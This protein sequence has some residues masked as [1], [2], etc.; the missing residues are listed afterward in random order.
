MATHIGG[1]D[2]KSS[3]SYEHCQTAAIV[4]TLCVQW[5]F[6]IVIQ[7]IGFGFG[8]LYATD[9]LEE[10]MTEAFLPNVREAIDDCHLRYYRLG[11]GAEVAPAAGRKSYLREFAHMAAVGWTGSDGKIR[12]DCGGSLIWENY[13][14]TAAHCVEDDANIPPDVVRLGDINL[15]DDTDDQYAQQLK[16]VEIVRHPEH[17]FGSRYHDLALLRLEKN[18]TLHDTVAPGCLWNDE[19]EIPFPTMEAT[20]WGATGFGEKSTPILLK[21]SLGVVK[22]EECNKHYKVGDR[23]L[24]QGLMNYHLCA[25]D[26]KMDTCPGDSGGPLQMKLLHNG[27]MTPFVVAVTSF[28]GVCGQSIPGVYMKV[29]PYI[30]WIS[31]ELAKRGEIIRDYSFK[32]DACALRYV[33]LR[34][35]EDDVVKHTTDGREILNFNNFHM[36][37]RDSTQTVSVHWPADS[38]PVPSNCNGVVIDEDTIVTLARCAIT[39]RNQPSHIMLRN[40]RNDIVRVYRH[41]DYRPNSFYNDIAILKVKDRFT[42]S[43]DF[44]PACIWSAY[45]LPNP[46]FYVTG[47]GRYDLNTLTGDPNETNRTI[48]QL[49]PRADILDIGNCTLPE[50]YSSR[51]G[52]GVTTEHLCFGNKL[53]L[54]PDSCEM[55]YGAPLRRNIWRFERHFEHIYALNLLGK[56]CGFGRAA[57]GIRLSYHSEWLKSVLLPN[58]RYESH[59]VQFLNT[60]LNDLD[61]CTGTDGST[62]L[63]VNIN[64]CPKIRYDVQAKRN[65]QFCNGGT[66]VCCPYDNIRNETSTSMSAS[67]LDDCESRYKQ[68]HEMYESYQPDRIDHF[69]HTVY[70]GWKTKDGSTEWI[71]SGTLITRS[72]VVSSAYCLMA[73]GNFP[74]LVNVAEGNPNATW[75]RPK[76]VGIKEVI[77][78][79]GYNATTLQYDIGLVRLV[80]PIVPTARKYPICLWQNETHTPLVLYRMAADETMSNF[81]LNFPKYNSDC[82]QHLR[83]LGR[84]ELQSNELCTDIDDTP[85]RSISGGPLVWYHRNLNDNSSTQYLV[86]T[87]SSTISAQRLGIHVR[88][89][90]YIGWIKSIAFG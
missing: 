44:V 66:I 69:Y 53:F 47:Q 6:L 57:L 3:F 41:P 27:K 13:V 65:V 55:L 62:G 58:Y 12:W 60:D 82:S 17:R 14:L 11:Y 29:A 5:F 70:L 24:K 7:N 90:S 19:K 85:Q 18:V 39:G 34:E 87:I 2:A 15:Y 49:S 43:Q 48:V 23:K 73:N 63:C 81:E 25:G 78:H 83:Q 22:P 32:P 76:P 21:V 89:S 30:P 28:G 20:G 26:V 75:S 16:I 33:H 64:R 74:T 37:L 61:Q 54:V 40:T 51:L 67:E 59:S 4:S 9:D 36:N 46:R 80:Q 10:K 71:C 79:P 31:A 88:I 38:S 68:F 84:R 72:I 42:F 1:E 52:R 56:D 8:A 86:G 45:N 50:E 77:I 35:Y